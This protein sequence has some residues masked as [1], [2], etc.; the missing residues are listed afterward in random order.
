MSK[1]L[2]KI[3][4]CGMGFLPLVFCYALN[5][6]CNWICTSKSVVKIILKHVLHCLKFVKSLFE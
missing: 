6:I 1:Q 5:L 3:R 2:S 4:G